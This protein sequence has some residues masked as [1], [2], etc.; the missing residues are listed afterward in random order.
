[1]SPNQATTAHLSSKS[2]GSLST[3]DWYMTSLH[4]LFLPLLRP[5]PVGDLGTAA[6]ITRD[7]TKILMVAYNKGVSSVPIHNV[8]RYL[9]S[10]GLDI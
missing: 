1:M 9:D 6:E 3:G 2:E 5:P 4:G 7:S 8:S 10:L